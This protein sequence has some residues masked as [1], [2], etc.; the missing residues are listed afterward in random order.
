MH[1]GV[2]LLC[3]VLSFIVIYLFLD[4]KKVYAIKNE[5]NDIPIAIL[6]HLIISCIVYA[7]FL[8]FYFIIRYAIVQP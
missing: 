3:A 8:I 4:Y 2:F 5:Y 1:I 6:S 7:V